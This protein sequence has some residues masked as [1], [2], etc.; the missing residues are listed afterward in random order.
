MIKESEQLGPDCEVVEEVV[1]EHLVPVVPD[2]LKTPVKAQH[3]LSV[4]SPDDVVF[5]TPNN[6][7]Y[8]RRRSS[9]FVQV[10]EYECD[11]EPSSHIEVISSAATT[12]DDAE[13]GMLDNQENKM[14]LWN[15]L[16]TVFRFASNKFMSRDDL[17]AIVPPAAEEDNEG[18]SLKRRLPSPKMCKSPQSPRNPPPKRICGRPPIARMRQQQK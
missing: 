17:V 10:E 18:S 13:P 11:D 5:Y 12:Y 9:I 8:R 15:V 6:A 14:S 7:K 16:S 2:I 3:E 1:E 4:N